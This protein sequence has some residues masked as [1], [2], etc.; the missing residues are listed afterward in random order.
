MT[1]SRRLQCLLG[2]SAAVFFAQTASAGVFNYIGYGARNQALGNSTVAAPTDGF[3]QAYNPALMAE[4]QGVV[5]SASVEGATTSFAPISNVLTDTTTLG[6]A[7]NTIGSPDM[8]TRDTFVFAIGY[9]APL[10][11][12][13]GRPVHFGINVVVPIQRVFEI[14]TPDMFL[15]EYSMYRS[16]TQRLVP[17]ITLAKRLS[18]RFSLGLGANFFLVQGSSTRA[19]LPTGG[20]STQNLTTE[21]DTGIA[22]MVGLLYDVAEHWKLGVNY[23]GNQNYQTQLNVDTQLNP[24]TGPTDILFTGNTSVAFDPDMFLLGG[25][26]SDDLDT[27]TAAARLELWNGYSGAAMILNFQSFSGSFSQTV[28][29]SPFHDI[30]AIQTGYEHRYLHSRLRFGYVYDPTPVPDQSGQTNIVDSDKHE[31]SAGYG[32]KWDHWLMDGKLNVDICAFYDYL[33]PKTVTK[34]NSA[35]IGAPGYSIGGSIFGYGATAT[36]EF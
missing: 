31:F 10:N 9:E 14:D 22:P 19:R 8:S 1:I 27:Y 12:A 26:Y 15:P 35:F 11:P 23:R 29:P 33:V 6:A 24:G 32:W 20:E 30:I 13:A 34:T 2:F 17:G 36:R 21:I 25:S 3:S 7:T 4:Q 18:D 5:F 28:P 16:D